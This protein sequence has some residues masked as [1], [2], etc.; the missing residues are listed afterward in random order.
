MPGLY[1]IEAVVNAV[2]DLLRLDARTSGI[3]WHY[4]RRTMQG[5]QVMPAGIVSGPGPASDA[6]RTMPAASGHEGAITVLVGIKYASERGVEQA[7]RDMQNGLDNVLAVLA[8]TPS[9][10]LSNVIEASAPLMAIFTS[11]NPEDTPPSA[12]AAVPLRVRLLPL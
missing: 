11:S 1:G 7:E 8:G 6:I 2:Y 9:L 12:E 3:K 4:G 10:G 5:I